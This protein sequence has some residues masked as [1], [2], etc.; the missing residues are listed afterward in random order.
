M[1]FPHLN[2]P[3][4]VNDIKS[5]GCD[6]ECLCANLYKLEDFITHIQGKK[7]D[8]VAVDYVFPVSFLE[9]LK[10]KL[11]GAKF[12]IGGNGF[13]DTF[14]K[15]PIDFA[16]SGA[17]RESFF[18]LTDAL[19][20]KRDLYE[21]PNLFLKLRKN[22]K[23]FID[24]SGK[25]RDFDLR[26]ELFP[27]S[28]VLEWKYIGFRKK[29]RSNYP[30]TVVA[31][32]GCP[33]RGKRPNHSP[34][35]LSVSSLA[36]RRDVF[37]ERA[38]KKIEDILKERL[39]GGCS[40]CTYGPFA[41]LP[42]DETVQ[43]LMEQ[44]RFLQKRYRLKRFA[45]GTENPF[46]FIVKLI[47]RSMRENIVLKEI[48]IRTRI[49][50]LN[51][52]EKVLR[53]VIVLAKKHDF[54]FSFIQLGFESFIQKDLDR[55]NK[56]YDV[57]E[58]FKAIQLIKKLERMAPDHFQ[59]YGHNFIGINPWITTRD[60]ENYLENAERSR[61]RFDL[62]GPFLRL[63]PGGLILYDRC[64]PIYQE[65]KKAGLLI[66]NPKGLDTYRYKDEKVTYFFKWM[67][68]QDAYLRKRYLAGRKSK[69]K[70]DQ[71]NKAYMQIQ[72]NSLRELNKVD[73]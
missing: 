20:N 53:G 43:C 35:D 62:E 56:G 2:M 55:Y 29:K 32:F 57:T 26:K 39:R 22:K 16:I 52:N 72:K 38:K 36:L 54:K 70:Y 25:D 21:V 13:L 15:G 40:F 51:Q 64:L 31:D 63:N 68:F 61:R 11:P 19:K 49:D 41:S 69:R 6:V 3:L 28:P 10:K 1:E 67:A 58:N 37:S 42:V 48:A 60:L 34:K 66:E 9:Q 18:K 27:F 47:Q 30:M 65:I 23:K 24:Y 59:S 33:Y 45:I 73:S 46:R 44:M 7:F 14:L 12:V 5:L 17:G 8:L 71:Y 4:F 50:W